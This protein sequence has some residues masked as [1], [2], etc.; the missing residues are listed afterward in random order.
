MPFRLPPAAS[1]LV[2]PVCA[3]CWSSYV[4]E[5][6][7]ASSF[8]FAPQFVSSGHESQKRA[9]SR[10]FSRQSESNWLQPDVGSPQR[11]GL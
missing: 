6:G 11:L 1:L 8:R 9:P 10:R 2:S 3:D 5:V 7:T 4:R